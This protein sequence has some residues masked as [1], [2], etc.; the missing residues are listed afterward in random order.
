MIK[1]ACPHCRAVQ[2]FPDAARGRVVRCAGCSRE[3][4]LPADDSVKTLEPVTAP[5]SV[6]E[7]QTLVGPTPGAANPARV[8]AAAPM[9]APLPPPKA[10]AAPLPPPPPVAPSASHPSL[11]IGPPPLPPPRGAPLSLPLLLVSFF[12]LIVT[13][14]CVFGIWQVLRPTKD[15][16]GDT[17]AISSSLG[18]F[19]GIEIGSKGVK[20]LVVDIVR[21]EGGSTVDYDFEIIEEKSINTNLGTLPSGKLDFDPKSLTRTIEAVK[22]LT[23]LSKEKHQVAADKI[24]VAVSSGVME[25]FQVNP[26]AAARAQVTLKERITPVAG[27]EPDFVESLEEGKLGF[28]TCVPSDDR[29]N[30]VLI[31][32]G[33]NNTKGGAYDADKVFYPM[34]LGFGTSRYQKAAAEAAE[35]QRRSYPDMATMLRPSLL[36]KEIK[37]DLNRTPILGVKKKAHLIGGG[38]WALATYTRPAA[39]ADKR[40]KLTASDIAKFRELVRS[41]APAAIPEK[42]VGTLPAG[43]TRD[44]AA[45]E[46]T[47]VQG[48]F[49][50]E[51]LIS[52]AEILTA[53]SEGYQFEGKTLSFFRKGQYGW[54]LGYMLKKSG[55]EK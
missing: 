28:L 30:S 49:N 35:K 45:A 43:K 48:V 46:I 42:V 27:T 26:D 13:A 2:T 12:S 33:S 41:T 23:S 32:L 54:M 5:D 29:T 20:L 53:L 8:A 22:E 52:A 36:D 9:P 39:V 19:A 37:E 7:E 31:D 11:P 1:Q 14:G 16:A 38:V 55:A 51:Q 24:Y 21:L 47:K 10:M 25:P 6:F 44:A 50:P 18:R 15:K 4:S 34:S 3:F 40:V 17:A